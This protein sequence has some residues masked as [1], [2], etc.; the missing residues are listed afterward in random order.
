MDLNNAVM[1]VTGASSGIGASTARAAAAAGA[2]LVLAARREDRLNE[3]AEQ[4]PDAIPVR[5]DVT[6]PAQVH[7]VVDA[8]LER[9]GRV[10]I[11]INNAGQGLHEPLEKVDPDD[12]RA[13][14]ELN[15]VAPLV[16]MQAVLPAM[17]AQGAGS[18]VNVSSGTTLRPLPGAGAYAASKAALNM[19]STI[20]RAEF[21]DSGI[22]VSTVYPFVTAT[23]FHR[24]LRAGA[25]PVRRE[26]APQAQ[27]PEQVA[28]V[29]LDLVRSGAEHADLIPA[30]LGG[31]Y[32][33]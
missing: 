9:Y 16:A 29:I 28:E 27:T 18:I 31:S 20:A 10:D 32:T 33:G 14:L 21:A 12:F 17:R 8:A 26:G 4:L 5:C 30:K 2:R 11:L 13:I 7:N 6:D 1:I 25:G 22:A 24:V 15:A 19:L 23:E 3:L